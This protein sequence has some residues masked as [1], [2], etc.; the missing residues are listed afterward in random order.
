M[1]VRRIAGAIMLS[2]CVVAASAAKK[3][4]P[5]TEKF[6]EKVITSVNPAGKSQKAYRIAPQL[7]AQADDAF[8][9][10]YND[11]MKELN[12]QKITPQEAVEKIFSK[13]GSSVYS[14]GESFSSEYIR[15]KNIVPYLKRYDELTRQMARVQRG[16]LEYNKIE[17][18]RNKSYGVMIVEGA[19][20]WPDMLAKLRRLFGVY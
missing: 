19:E 18:E 3:A 2:A 14:K 5:A 17:F 7:I 12:Q 6:G 16:S 9:K 1:S 20:S 4:V 11:V 10:A 8:K 15:L 13:T